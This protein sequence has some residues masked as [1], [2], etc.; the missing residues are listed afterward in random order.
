MNFHI[1]FCSS[2]HVIIELDEDAISDPGGKR[3]DHRHDRPT[4]PHARERNVPDVCNISDIHAVDNAV[5]YI[6]KLGEHCRKGKPAHQLWDGIAPEMIDSDRMFSPDF[7]IG[8]S[9]VFSI[10]HENP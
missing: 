8:T 6:D 7:H 5:E 1:L 10:S 2:R 9:F 3:G 4:D